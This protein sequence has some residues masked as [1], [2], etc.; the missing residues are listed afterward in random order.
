MNYLSAI[1]FVFLGGGFGSLS[2]FGIGKLSSFFSATRF[3]IGTLVANSLACIILGITIFYL[4][5]K[6]ESSHFIKY[7]IV[8]GF[9]GGFSTFSTF[10]LETVNLFKD[11]LL[12]FGILNI[13][14]SMSLAF[15]IL[16]I[17]AK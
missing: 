17:L 13:V 9:C 1:I 7:F 8:I 6:I 16:W 12:L 10:S 14:V 3:P 11:G 15:V 2:R 5:E 4:K